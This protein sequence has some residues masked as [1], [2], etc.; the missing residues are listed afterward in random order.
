M[1]EFKVDSLEGLKE[2]DSIVDK[3]LEDLKEAKI[4]GLTK[5]KGFQGVV[6]RFGFA[7]GPDSHGSKF[8]REIG[9]TGQRKPRRTGKGFPMPGRMGGDRQTL[10]GVKIVDVIAE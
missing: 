4:S 6:K 1:K 8:H 3:L 2:G 7:G 9:S 10:R 5:G